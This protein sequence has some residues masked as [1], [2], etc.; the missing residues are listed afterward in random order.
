MPSVN[1]DSARKF[2]QIKDLRAQLAKVC[3]L[4]NSF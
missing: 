4:K 2:N 3:R 1:P